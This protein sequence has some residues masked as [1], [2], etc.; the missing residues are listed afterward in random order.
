MCASVGDVK[1]MTAAARVRGGDDGPGLERVRVDVDARRAVGAD[2]D[3]VLREAVGREDDAGPE[4]VV[5]EGRVERVDVARYDAGT[6][7]LF[8]RVSPRGG[9]KA[10]RT[11]GPRPRTG[12]AALM[13]WTR[14]ERSTRGLAAASRNLRATRP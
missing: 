6:G 11:R 12:S 4:A 14:A 5:R 9:K 10:G 7:S 3:R 13:A 2:E 8:C 1:K